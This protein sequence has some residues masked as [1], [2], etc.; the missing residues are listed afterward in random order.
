MKW[1]AKEKKFGKPIKGTIYQCKAQN[2]NSKN[3]ISIELKAVIEDDCFWRS[4]DD[5]SEIDEWNWDVI[6]WVKK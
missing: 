3:V 5:N 2:H 1:E 6:E 4:V